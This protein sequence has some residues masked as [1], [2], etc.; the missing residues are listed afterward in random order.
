M[1]GPDASSADDP[2]FRRLADLD[3]L[4]HEPARLSI[5]TA[6]STCRQAD[7]TYLRRITGLTKGNLSSHLS[8]LEEAGFVDIEKTFE[9]KSPVTY[10]RLT[11]TG[12][13]TIARYWDELQNL[14]QDAADWEPDRDA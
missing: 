11:E 14:R 4:V 8:R 2:P 10:A 9:G 7:F 6:L 13:R 5:L 12:R 1:P 3:K